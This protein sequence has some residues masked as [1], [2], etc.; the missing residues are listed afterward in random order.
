MTLPAAPTMA[1]S[2]AYLPE[3]GAPHKGNPERKRR[4]AKVEYNEWN[5]NS[6]DC[7]A[8]PLPRPRSRN[9]IAPEP[10]QAVA[11]ATPNVSGQRLAGA[12]VAPRLIAR[13]RQQRRTAPPG[14]VGAGSQAASP[15][16]TPNGGAPMLSQIGKD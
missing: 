6:R 14:P 1:N 12:P 2:M 13:I 4:E 16:S 3:E 10:H 15:L 8:F 9:R 7:A 11:G 5:K